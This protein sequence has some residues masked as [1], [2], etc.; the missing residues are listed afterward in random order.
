MPGEN[1]S[2]SEAVAITPS[3]TANFAQVVKG[4][5]VG[6]GGDVVI[7]TQ[8]GAVVTFKNAVS[9]SIIP[10]YA[11]RVNSTGTIATDLVGLYR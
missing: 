5:Y 6:V 7:V 1:A 8:S 3:D 4:I 11:K 2:A 10:V 9:G